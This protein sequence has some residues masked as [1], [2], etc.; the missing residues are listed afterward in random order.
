[1]L[2]FPGNK[3]VSI[4]A[5]DAPGNV[6]IPG[7]FQGRKGMEIVTGTAFSSGFAEEADVAPATGVRPERVS[8][9]WRTA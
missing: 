6:E 5:I 3:A 1:M 8:I 2:F 4:R 9:V 7:I